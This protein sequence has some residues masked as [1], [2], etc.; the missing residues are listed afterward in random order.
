MHGSIAPSFVEE[1]TS[2]VERGEEVDVGVGAEPV[3]VADLEVGPEVAVVVG[4]T[5]VVT[6]E[7]HAVVL[8]N[9]L[10][11]V[12]GEVLGGVPEGGNGL[13][14]FVKTESEAV[15]LLVVGHELERVVVD[16][17]VQLDAG[18]DAPVPLVVEHQGVAEEEA[19]FV[20]AH[21]PV[22][23]G[24]A[25]DD[26]LLLHLLADPGGLVLVNP[27]GERPMLLWNLAILGLSR[28]ERRCNPLEFVVE[29][30]IVQ[31]HPVVVELAVEAVLDVA[32]GLGDLPDVGI[33]GEGDEGSVHAVAGHG[34]GEGCFLI[35]GGSCDWRDGRDWRVTRDG[36]IGGAWRD[37]IFVGRGPAR[38][39]H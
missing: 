12:L 31:E 13:D 8:D 10:G 22:A 7:L 37:G 24:V 6:K 23:D 30:V 26:L 4:L 35:W 19:G 15:L 33:A 16:V 11:V 34:L 28:H 2:M 38:S 14:V 1:T 27:F 18:L 20:T 3:K 32:N 25:V 9:V 21:V 17:A 39:R 5:A 29:L 36:G